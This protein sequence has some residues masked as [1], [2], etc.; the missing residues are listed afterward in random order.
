MVRKAI[1]ILVVILPLV[2][3]GC[4]QEETTGPENAGKSG[5]GTTLQ[6]VSGTAEYSIEETDVPFIEENDTVNIGDML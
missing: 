1:L 2:F 4:V 3:A 5:T 6:G